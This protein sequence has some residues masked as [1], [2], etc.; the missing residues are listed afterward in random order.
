[1]AKQLPTPDQAVTYWQNGLRNATEK[2]RNGLERV[3]EAP[4]RKAADAA[5]KWLNNIQTSVNRYKKNV[6]AVSLEDW[7]QKTIDKG[8]PRIASGADAAGDKMKAA[9]ERNFA[10]I[11]KGLEALDKMPKR[12][13]E[14][15][16][17]RMVYM[18]R[19]M[20]KLRG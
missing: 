18:T 11:E 9:M 1:M 19:H 10:H 6:A 12:T 4:G 16:I 3:Q 8:I 2:I 5:D 7:R 13:I 15:S 14:D 20:A 17:N